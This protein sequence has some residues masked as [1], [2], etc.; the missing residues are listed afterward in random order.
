LQRQLEQVLFTP[1]SDAP[2]RDQLT[3][4][5]ATLE[6]VRAL[7]G[8]D[9]EPYGEVPVFELRAALAS[10]P[11]APKVKRLEGNG[12]TLRYDG[13]GPAIALGAEAPKGQGPSYGKLFEMV[14]ILQTNEAGLQRDLAAANAKIAELEVDVKLQQQAGRAHLQAADAAKA[15]V[16]D[17]TDRGYKAAQ[18]LIEANA[19]IADQVTI[20]EQANAIAKSALERSAEMIRQ[21]DAA[22]A[23]ADAA[24]REM[25]T[26]HQQT[27]VALRGRD[28]LAARVKELE[29]KN[30]NLLHTIQSDSGDACTPEERNVLGA[31][32]AMELGD[33]DPDADPLEPQEVGE[34]CYIYTDDQHVIVR[35]EL[36]NR[37]AKAKRGGK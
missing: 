23:R 9:R 2:L 22:N 36:A 31:C 30:R 32:K 35:A 26:A 28:Q 16:K 27:E 10:Q 29:A 34:D 33:D 13:A 1:C 7:V 21:R 3:A 17:L 25:H 12:G 4:A 8:E 18:L 37:A 6:R 5:T 14:S 24:E 15:Q 19:R 20:A 11:E